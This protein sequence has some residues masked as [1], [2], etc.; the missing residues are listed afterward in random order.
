[1]YINNAANFPD[2]LHVSDNGRVV[3]RVFDAPG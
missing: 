1:M 3:R 2:Y